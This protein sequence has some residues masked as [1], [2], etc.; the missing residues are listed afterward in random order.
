[1]AVTELMSDAINLQKRSDDTPVTIVRILTGT[2]NDHIYGNDAAVSKFKKFLKIGGEIRVLVWTE[3][4]D[5]DCQL[6]TLSNENER[7]QIRESGTV[8][9]G[10]ELNHFFVVDTKS[11]RF[12]QPHAPVPAGKFE[13]FSPEIPASICFHDPE[14]AKQLVKFFDDIW[15]FCQNPV[16]VS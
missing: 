16:A 7:L 9:R 14:T 11:Y 8:A 15:A 13:D 10:D 4:I 2:C 3:S 1:M 5:W 6:A 12:E